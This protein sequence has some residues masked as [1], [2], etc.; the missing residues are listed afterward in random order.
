MVTSSVPSITDSATPLVNEWNHVFPGTAEDACKSWLL[1]LAARAIM[2]TAITSGLCLKHNEVDK[3][4]N[5]INKKNIQKFVI[6][7]YGQHWL[8]LN[9][10]WV[11]I[12]FLQVTYNY[13]T[14]D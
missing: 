7:H 3:L 10:R 12:Y 1:N 2:A 14:F 11:F 9:F 13:K 4:K 8:G 6:Y 5:K